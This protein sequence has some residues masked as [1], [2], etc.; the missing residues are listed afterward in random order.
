ME[1]FVAL[2]LLKLRG[3]SDERYALH[4]FRDLDGLEVDLI[5]ELSVGMLVAFQMKAS[6]TVTA[7]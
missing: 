2:E 5:A 7:S 4:H 1:Q 6:Q 3:W